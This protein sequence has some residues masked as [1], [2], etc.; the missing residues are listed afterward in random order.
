[1]YIKS[2]IRIISS[3]NAELY[4]SVFS[5]GVVLNR[6]ELRNINPEAALT[7]KD[8]RNGDDERE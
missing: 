7:R 8:E 1:M 6:E 2:S 5:T 3:G 4:A